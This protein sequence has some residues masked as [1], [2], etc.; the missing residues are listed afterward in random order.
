MTTIHAT[1]ED[2]G[3]VE[4]TVADVTA[5]RCIEDGTASYQ[6]RCPRCRMSTAKPAAPKTIDLLVAAG[7]ELIE[8][9][10]P[11]ELLEPREGGM[12]THDDMLDFHV[13]LDDPADPWFGSVARG[14]A[15]LD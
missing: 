10:L 12:F 3:D 2:C 15:H 7:V 5:R 11:S 1:C 13:L 9:R 8:W 14:V 4:L 6:F